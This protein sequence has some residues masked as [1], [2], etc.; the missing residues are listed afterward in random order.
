MPT[1]IFGT[2]LVHALAYLCTTSKQIIAQKSLLM[3]A[4]WF[5]HPHCYT[6][7]QEMQGDPWK[8]RW[9]A[10]EDVLFAIKIVTTMKYIL[11]Y[12]F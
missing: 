8:R 3:N 12:T 2:F 7:P 4:H 6:Q 10:A 1:V 9:I 11:H 5:I